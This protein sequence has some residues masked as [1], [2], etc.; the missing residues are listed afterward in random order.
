MKEKCRYRKQRGSGST[1]CTVEVVAVEKYCFLHKF[2]RARDG[3]KVE[4]K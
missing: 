3:K 1:G 2:I 4:R